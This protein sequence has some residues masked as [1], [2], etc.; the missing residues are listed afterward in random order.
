MAQPT[1]WN[2]SYPSGL[3]WDHPV[4]GHERTTLN[5]LFQTAVE[6]FGDRPCVE[7]LGRRLTYSEVGDQ[8]ALFARGLQRLGVEPGDRVGI[9]LPNTPYAVIA[10]YG[11]LATGATV[12]NFNPL[13]AHQEI[14]HQVEDSGTKIMVTLNLKVLYRKIER[15]LEE[16][17]CL[18]RVVVCR[19][20]DCLPIT[21]SLLFSI[22][23]RAELA[24]IEPRDEVVAY[25]VVIDHEEPVEPVVLDP[26][27]DI[28][29]LQ[30]TGGTTGVPKGAMLSHANLVA[31]TEQVTLWF[32]GLEEGEE[33]ILGVLPLFHVFAMTV[34]MNMSIR[35]GAEMILLPKFDLKQLLDTV[36]R[37]RPTVLPGVPTLFNAVNECTSLERYDLQS[38]KYCISGGAPL[39]LDVRERFE[40]VTECSLVEGYGLSEFSPVAT[41]NPLGGVSKVGSTG[42]PLPQTEVSIRD[43]EDATRVLPTGEHGEIFLRGPQLML[44]YW[45]RPDETA[46]VMK[47]GWLR[48]GDVGYLDDD[49]Y[50][51]IVDR[52]KDLILCNGYNVYPRAIE[53]AIYQHPDVLEVIVCGIPDQRRGEVPKAFIRKLDESELTRAELID[54]LAD[55]ISPIE[56]PR[57]V[58]FRPEL[59]KTAIGKLSK[60]A[61]VEE[62]SARAALK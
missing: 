8:V 2:S 43:L 34:V 22:F 5:E 53:E 62:E 52:Q 11:I 24:R 42:I 20:T 12:V 54:F 32:T 37:K 26:E 3:S 21:K 29:V 33:R 61:L 57:E 6:K 1:P 25:D 4:P 17:P 28:A 49:G 51:F 56:L 47:D 44:G 18:E 31:N 58:E 30:Y 50:L 40:A 13:Y 46:D 16:S 48:T 41:C 9:F 10:Y 45:Q 15:V 39:P 7:F 38:I 23:K 19:M 35:T 27:Q 14:V 60:R 36:Q 55:K 59:P